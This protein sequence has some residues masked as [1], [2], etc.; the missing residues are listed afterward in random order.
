MDD[1]LKSLS[2]SNADLEHPAAVVGADQHRQLVEV[3]DS[4]GWR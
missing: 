4:M 3:E 2:D 1:E